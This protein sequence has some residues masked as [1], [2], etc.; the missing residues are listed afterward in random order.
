MK[1]VVIGLFF[2][3]LVLHQDC[4]LWENDAAVMGFI[5][6]GLFYH[7]CYSVAV[8]LLAALAIRFAWPVKLEEWAAEGEPEAAAV[9]RK[10]EKVQ[11]KVR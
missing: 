6:V 1:K 9:K 10:L 8:A 4:W 7:A 11:Y 2:L 3:M 5:P